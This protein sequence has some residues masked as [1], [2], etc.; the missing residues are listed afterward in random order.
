MAHD[1]F[2]SARRAHNNLS[3]LA[4]PVMRQGASAP[5]SLDLVDFKIKLVH[6]VLGCTGLVPSTRASG[7]THNLSEIELI[8]PGALIRKYW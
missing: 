3:D 5:S 1:G 4:V 6:F 2:L 7:P 8:R